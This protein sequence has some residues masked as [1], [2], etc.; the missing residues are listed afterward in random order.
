MADLP[1]LQARL[2]EAEAALHALMMGTRV[3]SVQ[4]DTKQVRYTE[5]DQGKLRGYI[6]ELRGQIQA[7]GGMGTRRQAIGVRF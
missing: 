3:V 1:T 2:T 5:T 4:T 6:A 7:L